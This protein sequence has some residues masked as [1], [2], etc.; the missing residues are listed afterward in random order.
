MP[1][2]HSVAQIQQ[3]VQYVLVYLTEIKQHVIVAL[4]IFRM[5]HINVKNVQITVLV[6]IKMDASYVLIPL[7]CCLLLL[8]YVKTVHMIM[9]YY[10]IAYHVNILVKIV[11]LIPIVFPVY[12]M[13]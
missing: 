9:E 7:I 12:K 10:Q 5:F 8:V 4:D 1:V 11:N 2:L 13:V 3:T 6:V